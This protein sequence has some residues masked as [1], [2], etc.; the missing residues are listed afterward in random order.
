MRD[1]S[2]FSV[3]GNAAGGNTDDKDVVGEVHGGDTPEERL[4]PVVV[5]KRSHALPEMNCKPRSR[6]VTKKKGHIETTLE[7]NRKVF[8]LDVTIDSIEGVCAENNDGSW[9]VSFDGISGEEL[10]LSIVANGNLISTPIV[11]KVKSQGISG[12]EGQL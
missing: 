8:S 10:K 4:V 5:V 1:Y 6:Y 12:G 7:F 11:L 2:Q 3:G 9:T